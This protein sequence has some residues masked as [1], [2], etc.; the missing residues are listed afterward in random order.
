MLNAFNRKHS[1]PLSFR[2]SK[3]FSKVILKAVYVGVLSAMIFAPCLIKA[4]N[5]PEGSG[6]SE[7]YESDEMF[8]KISLQEVTWVCGVQK[9]AKGG[10]L[11]MECEAESARGF[12]ESEPVKRVNGS[13][14][15]ADDTNDA[16]HQGA[17]E[18]GSGVGHLLWLILVATATGIVVTIT[19]NF[20]IWR[21]IG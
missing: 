4:A 16:S 11:V 18:S 7:F 14:I 6:V 15:S 3:R 21:Y 12:E 9:V 1:A 17:Q 8:P 2:V 10:K 13:K 5:L 20:L 19:G